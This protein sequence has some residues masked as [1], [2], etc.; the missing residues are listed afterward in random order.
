MGSVTHAEQPAATQAGNKSGLKRILDAHT[1]SA[2]AHAATKSVV[3]AAATPDQ[4]LAQ[5]RYMKAKGFCFHSM[6]NAGHRVA[7]RDQNVRGVAAKPLP[8]NLKV[9]DWPETQSS[10]EQLQLDL[11]ERLTKPVREQLEQQ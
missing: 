8:S 11:V 6:K 4:S 5:Q 2:P 10:K 7:K 9:D 1:S 3:E